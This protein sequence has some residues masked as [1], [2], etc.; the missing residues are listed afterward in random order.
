[1]NKVDYLL[2]CLME[3]LAEVQQACA[4]SL[5]FGLEDHRPGTEDRNI[6]ELWTEINDVYAILDMLVEH[7]ILLVRN[8]YRIDLKK[9]KVNKFMQYSED[10]GRLDNDEDSR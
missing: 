5:R 9:A 2:V 10:V 6:D 8:E 1:M 4:K 3:E 7:N